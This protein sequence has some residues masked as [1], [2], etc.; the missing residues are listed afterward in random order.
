MKNQ[1]VA[2]I[3]DF[4]KYGLLRFLS[5]SGENALRLGVMWYLTE[6]IA[7]P[8]GRR[9][10]YLTV[11]SPNAYSAAD[12]RLFSELADVVRCKARDI[13]QIAQ[14]R[15]LPSDT[16]FFTR[17]LTVRNR[18]QW[19]EEGLSFVAPSSLVFL[20]PDNGLANDGK[21]AHRMCYATLD[22]VR[23]LHDQGHSVVVIQFLHRRQSH[24]AQLSG[25]VNHLRRALPTGAPQAF[26]LRWHA[27][28][29]VGF[30]VI[31]LPEHA[32][33]LVK[34]TEQLFQSSWAGLFERH[35]ANNC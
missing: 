12:P 32:T 17:Q 33:T 7:C 6:N 2:D 26:A 25:W 9:T 31:P 10:D 28:S 19:F 27:V 3:N 30:L 14:R 20:D 8:D 29:S 22:E 13:S 4:A 18:S 11:P 21:G 34:R 35:T 23:R 1:Y 15:I 16:L 24:A 5:G